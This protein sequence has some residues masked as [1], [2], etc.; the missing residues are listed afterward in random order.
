MYTLLF[1]KLIKLLT[2]KKNNIVFFSYT[3]I[4]IISDF[5]KILDEKCKERK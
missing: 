4:P 5:R 1:I 3:L 2:K